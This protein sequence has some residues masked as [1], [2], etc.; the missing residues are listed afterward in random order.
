MREDH[1]PGAVCQ[2]FPGGAGHNLIE[3]DAARGPLKVGEACKLVLFEAAFE[4]VR[5]LF[6]VTGPAV[7]LGPAIKLPVIVK[8]WGPPKVKGMP[9]KS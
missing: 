7:Q 6:T 8:A 9:F 3:R 2:I 1:A 5:L 4:R